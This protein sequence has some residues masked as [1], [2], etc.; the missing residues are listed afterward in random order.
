MKF[1]QMKKLLVAG[2]AVLVATTFTAC[3]GGGS[4]SNPIIAG[5]TGP[6]VEVVNGDVLLSMTFQQVSVSA[7][8][9]IPIPKLPNSSIEVGPDF[10]SGGTLLVVTVAVADFLGSSAANFNPT[11]LPGGRPLPGVAAGQVPAIAINV[12]QLF[13]MT[14]YVGPTVLGFFVPFKQLN[15]D[16]AIV[17]FAFYNTA[18]S[19]VGE[20]SLVG[21]DASGNNAGILAL[22]DAN[23][24]GII[25]GATAN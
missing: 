10:Q 20:I 6:T 17:T 12:P 8:A 7:G 3:G 23:L 16:G 2:L 18:G 4:G 14:F 5:I 25:G 11:E 24:A 13:N 15:I 9:T 1:L 19:E 22:V 21:S